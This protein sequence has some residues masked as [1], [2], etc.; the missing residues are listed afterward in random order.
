MV[1][2][3]NDKA[4][5]LLKYDIENRQKKDLMTFEKACYFVENLNLRRVIIPIDVLLDINGIY[6]GIVMDYYDNLF[7]SKKK[8]HVFIKNQEILLVEI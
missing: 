7:D 6:I 1:F 5:K 2:K 3:Y 8:I 4:L